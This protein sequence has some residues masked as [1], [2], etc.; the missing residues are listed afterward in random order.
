MWLRRGVAGQ[1]PYRMTAYQLRRD[2]LLQAASWKLARRLSWAVSTLDDQ[3]A[4]TR[5][6]GTLILTQAGLEYLCRLHPE[7]QRQLGEFLGVAFR[8]STAR[9]QMEH[10]DITGR[11]V[12]WDVAPYRQHELSSCEMEALENLL[13]DLP[14]FMQM[15]QAAGPVTYY[16]STCWVA[17]MLGCRR[18]LHWD[19]EVGQVYWG[20]LE[21]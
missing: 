21:P 19:V 5:F 8:D 9:W 15:G 13:S 11:L 14:S 10:G 3:F 16:E 4:L 20:M 2:E 12:S 6:K 1:S 7:D 17:G 18:P